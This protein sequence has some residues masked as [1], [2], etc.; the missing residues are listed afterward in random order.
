MPE[1]GLDD[2]R[3]MSV[4]RTPRSGCIAKRRNTPT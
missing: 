1:Y 2:A 3:L 4:S